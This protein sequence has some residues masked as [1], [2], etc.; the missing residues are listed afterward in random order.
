MF[1][2]VNNRIEENTFQHK[3]E[4]SLFLPKIATLQT[5]MLFFVSSLTD[6]ESSNNNY[7]DIIL[8]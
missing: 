4:T 3:K 1:K 2:A 6:S 5:E 8:G 7:Y